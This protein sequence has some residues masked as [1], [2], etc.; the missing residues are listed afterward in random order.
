MANDI[1]LLAI[2]IV[3]RVV[4]IHYKWFLSRPEVSTPLNSWLRL[5]EGV[6]LYKSGNAPSSL[7]KLKFK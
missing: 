1:V 2:S 4:A 7:N 5:T 6:H 3:V